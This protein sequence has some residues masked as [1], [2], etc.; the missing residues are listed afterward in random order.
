MQ[1][2]AGEILWFNSHIMIGKRL[3][4]HKSLISCGV[5]IIKDL[6]NQN[7]FFSYQQFKIKYLEANIDFVTYSGIIRAIP[8]EWKQM[9]IQANWEVVPVTKP[10]MDKILRAKGSAA[11]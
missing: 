11:K 7:V 9:L 5:L 2:V 4:F 1:E 3:L 8:L 10:L 6:C